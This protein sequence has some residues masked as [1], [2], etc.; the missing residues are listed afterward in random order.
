MVHRFRWVCVFK[1]QPLTSSAPTLP[2]TDELIKGETRGRLPIPRTVAQALL[3]IWFV[4]VI[5]SCLTWYS[6]GVPGAIMV[7]LITAVLNHG[8]GINGF[9]WTFRDWTMILLF[10]VG[11]TASRSIADSVGFP[12]QEQLLIDVDRIIGSRSCTP[13]T[14]LRRWC[15]WR[16]RIG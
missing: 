3:G 10:F 2:R 1:D 14:L 16:W 13:A 6:A 12:I 11:Y 4:A 7:V 8:K 5:V 15:H 9:L